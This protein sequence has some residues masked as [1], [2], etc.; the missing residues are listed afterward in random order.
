M[1]DQ[2]PDWL[3][4]DRAVEAVDAAESAHRI[5]RERGWNLM[6]APFDHARRARCQIHIAHGAMHDG[7]AGIGNQIDFIVFQPDA[8]HQL[9]AFI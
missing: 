2:R 1:S 6:A 8:V 5:G 7:A 4:V 9:P 3:S